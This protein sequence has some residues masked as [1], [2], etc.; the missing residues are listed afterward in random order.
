MRLTELETDNVM[1]AIRHYFGTRDCVFA[2]NLIYMAF[3]VR[4]NTDYK[5]TFKDG[6]VD[7]IHILDGG[8]W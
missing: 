1:N 6:K 5:L 7:E 4:L 3:E 8:N 2:D